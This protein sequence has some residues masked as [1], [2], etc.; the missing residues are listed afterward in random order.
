MIS[1]ITTGQKQDIS[2]DALPSG[3]Y[4]LNAGDETYKI[5]IE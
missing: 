3:M 1:G 2:I 4:V 5:V